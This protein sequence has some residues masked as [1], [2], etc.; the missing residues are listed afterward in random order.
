MRI[1]LH[2]KQLAFTCRPVHLVNNGGEQH[3]SEFKE[4]NPAGEVPVLVHDGFIL[5]QS[6]AIL[7]YLD[8][9]FPSPRL[10]PESPKQQA[11][12]LQLCEAV[13]SGIH[14]LQNSKVLNRL[15]SQHGFSEEAKKDW[16]AYWITQGFISLDTV[17]KKVAGSCCIGDEISAADL[18]L[19]PQI[20]NARRFKVDMNLFPTLLRVETHLLN[21]PAFQAAS[22]NN[23]PDTP[24]QA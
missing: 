24:Q 23:Q 5:S 21:N 7:Q 13:N 14:P 8:A 1:A 2:L 12:C 19:V 15:A 6:M 18:Y 17:V 16:A 9:V 22:P 20:F 10:F 4:L 3:L 11:I